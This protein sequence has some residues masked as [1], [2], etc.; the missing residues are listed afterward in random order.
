VSARPKLRV[1]LRQA[2]RL[3]SGSPWVYSNEVI[4]DR[5]AKALPPGSLVD[6]VSEQGQEFGTACFSPHS[7]IAARVLSRQPGKAIDT[8]FFRERIER[9]RRLRDRLIPQKNYRLL[10]AESDGCPGL[11]V[12]RFGDVLV[13]QSGTAGMDELA[14]LWI[15]ALR[16]ECDPQAIVVKNN[17]ASRAHE[18]LPEDIRITFGELPEECIVE[19]GGIRHAVD[20]M[21]GQ[22]TGWYFDQRDNRAFLAMLSKGSTLLDAFSYTGALALAALQS[23]ATSATLMDS[24]QSAL[25]TAARTARKHGLEDRAEFRKCDVLIELEE[26][27]PTIE[28]FDVVSCDPPPF[29]RSRKELESGARGYRKLARLAAPLVNPGGFLCLASCSHGIDAE[30]FQLECTHGIARAGRSSRLIRASGAAPDHPVHPML[31]ETAYLKSLV[32]QLD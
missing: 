29:V 21:A 27:G 22:K 19:E 14:P 20:V 3:K 10:H 18:N 8:D 26:L 24:S 30:R 25:D 2:A 32:Y 7:L 15:E 5:A 4:M 1:N 16:L 12:D 17:S 31:P 23:G 9:A 13:A 6:I 28:R 11:V